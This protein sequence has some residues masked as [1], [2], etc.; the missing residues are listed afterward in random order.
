MSKTIQIRDVSEALHRRLKARAGERRAFAV[1][2]PVEG[3]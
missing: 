1:G 2:F 3:D